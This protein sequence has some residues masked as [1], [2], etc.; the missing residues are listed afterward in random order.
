MRENDLSSQ[1]VNL[2]NEI[3]ENLNNP[4]YWKNKYEKL[5]F[6]DELRLD[7]IFRELINGEY[8]A[9]MWADDYPYSIY[10]ENKGYNK[11]EKGNT[12]MEEEKLPDKLNDIKLIEQS[13]HHEYDVFLS[14]ANIDKSRY[15]NELYK[16]LKLLGINVFYDTTAIGWGDNWKQIILDG[17]CSAEFAIIVISKNFFGREWTNRELQE[18]LSMQNERGQKTILPILYEITVK[19]LIGY[20]PFL[21]DIQCLSA[22]DYSK[23]KIALKFAEQFIKRIRNQ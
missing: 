23:D 19:D 18:F 15:V 17:V 13:E 12:Q 2:L 6:H 7:S 5:S 20:Y 21:G 22:M 14:H 4:N 16:S 9:A 1:A 10:V 11:A 8:I 3:I